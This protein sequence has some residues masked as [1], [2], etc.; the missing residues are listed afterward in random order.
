MNFLREFFGERIISK[1]LWPPRS[2]DLTPPD[3]FLWGYLKGRVY[4]NRPQTLDE[5]KSNITMEINLINVSV[6]HK[7]ATNVVKRVRAC[8]NEQGSHFE[9]ML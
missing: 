4:K 7:V 9:Y 1:G 8:I 5:L 2:P 3:F 6:L